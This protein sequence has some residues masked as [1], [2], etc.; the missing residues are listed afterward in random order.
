VPVLANVFRNT[1]VVF[2][3][4]E[5]RV[6][7]FDNKVN[8]GCCAEAADVVVHVVLPHAPL[9]LDGLWAVAWYMQAKLPVELLFGFILNLGI[10]LQDGEK[11]E[12][13][14]VKVFGVA[15]L[16]EGLLGVGK[17]ATRE[18]GKVCL[19]SVALLDCKDHLVEATEVVLLS[20]AEGEDQRV[21]EGGE[22]GHLG[23]SVVGWMSHLLLKK[24]G[25][26]AVF[27]PAPPE[28]D[29]S[30]KITDNVSS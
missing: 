12:L 14:L 4:V 3:I 16:F 8:V 17:L 25:N 10:R 29:V 30:K 11:V 9:S 26:R 24:E 22:L 20:L 1:D 7:D 15:Q 2:N 13:R 28:L 19:E 18:V 6:A 21:E 5:N 23:Y 27:I